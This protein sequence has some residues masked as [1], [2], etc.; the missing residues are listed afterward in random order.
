M[1]SISYTR[2][3]S[4]PNSREEILALGKEFDVKRNLS[5]KSIN[6]IVSYCLQFLTTWYF[7]R[8]EIEVDLLAKLADGSDPKTSMKP[9]GKYSPTAQLQT[10][11]IAQTIDGIKRP[12]NIEI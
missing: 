3:F 9:F 1:C 2:E 7:Q 8:L 12:V 4:A 6:H 5:M 10:S 11:C